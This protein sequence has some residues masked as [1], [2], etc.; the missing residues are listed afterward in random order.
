MG[1]GVSLVMIAVGAILRFATTATVHG[2]NIQTIG[3][4]LIIIG[5]VGFVVSLF[6]WGSWGGYGMSGRS[7]H[8]TRVT[9]SGTYGDPYATQQYPPYQGG[10]AGQGRV[11]TQV[12]EDQLL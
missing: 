11:V 10:P 1:V 8:R 12:E 3:L 9:R 7:R 6:F 5:V 2:F 4:I